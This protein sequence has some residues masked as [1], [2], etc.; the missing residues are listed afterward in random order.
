MK[1]IVRNTL[2]ICAL[3]P[4]VLPTIVWCCTVNYPTEAHSC[5]KSDSIDYSRYGAPPVWT[6]CPMTHAEAE[7]LVRQAWKEA[8][9]MLDACGQDVLC[10]PGYIDVT[11]SE[12]PWWN[13]LYFDGDTAYDAH[14]KVPTIFYCQIQRSPS[15]Y[16]RSTNTGLREES[17]MTLDAAKCSNRQSYSLDVRRCGYPIT[18]LVKREKFYTTIEI[19]PMLYEGGKLFM[20]SEVGSQDGPW[21]QSAL[22]A[23]EY[24]ILHEL[25]HFESYI[26][27]HICNC[28]NKP[29]IVDGSEDGANAFASSVFRYLEI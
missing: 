7:A 26:S 4:V 20:E 12:H 5:A 24:L 11:S 28:A 8:K 27:H 13:K 19:F 25:G 17:I 9:K 3:I 6:D 15:A 1:S 18:G 2:M 29:P 16:A 23:T 14:V 22:E 10:R 21:A